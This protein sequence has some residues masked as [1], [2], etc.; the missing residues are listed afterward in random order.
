MYNT[1]KY[2][3]DNFSIA[4]KDILHLVSRYDAAETQ[5]SPEKWPR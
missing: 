3:Y 2:I 5:N 4:D 1:S